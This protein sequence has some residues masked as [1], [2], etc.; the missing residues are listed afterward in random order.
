MTG[1]HYSDNL[2]NTLLRPYIFVDND[3]LKELQSNPSLVENLTAALN[4][5]KLYVH[6]LT[7]F[8]FLRNISIL[9]TK[10]IKERFLN[11]FLF[12]KIGPE[13]HLKFIP[14]FTD[15][16]LLLSSIYTLKQYKGDSSYVDLIL[17]G[18]LM[19]LS[20]RGALLTGNAKDF[21]RCVFDVLS[22]IN[23]DQEDDHMK[24]FCIVGFNKEKFDKCNKEL[25]ELDFRQTIKILKKINHPASKET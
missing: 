25:K 10:L 22:V 14:K 9:E 15:N 17:A 2:Q 20:D 21:P 16:A 18:M 19:S 1:F 4:S 11:S 7:E 23:V 24:A 3:V 12:K 13:T 6:P 8:E 5:R